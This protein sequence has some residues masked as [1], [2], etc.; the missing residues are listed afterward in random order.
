LGNIKYIIGDRILD[1][2]MPQPQTRSEI[3]IQKLEILANKYPKWYGIQ[4][5]ILACVGYAYIWVLILVVCL[6]FYYKQTWFDRYLLLTSI[7]KTIFFAILSF[8]LF[9][10][11]FTHISPPKGIDLNLQNRDNV[12]LKTYLKNISLAIGSIQIDRVIVTTDVNIDLLQL[13][14]VGLLGRKQTLLIIGMPLMLA[15]NPLQLKAILACEFGLLSD[16]IPR[17]NNWV[18][19]QVKTYIYLLDN[20][21][22]NHKF[23]LLILPFWRWYVPLLDTY[24]LL[25]RRQ[26]Q[27]NADRLAAKIVGTKNLVNAVV[28]LEV[29]RQFISEKFW[30]DIDRNHGIEPQPP[31]NIFELMERSILTECNPEDAARWLKASLDR[32]SDLQNIHP[33]LL[34]RLLALGY[35]D[36]SPDLAVGVGSTHNSARTYLGNAF[37]SIIAR[38]DRDWVVAETRSW[39][40]KFIQLQRAKTSVDRLVDKFDRDSLTIDES[41]RLATR[42]I[43]LGEI[44]NSIVMF[45]QILA[46]N[47]NHAKTN[48]WLGTILL[49][50]GNLAGIEYLTTAMNVDPGTIFGA[51]TT[52]RQ[53]A[54][55]IADLDPAAADNLK[56]IAS[57]YY[58]Y[59]LTNSRKDIKFKTKDLYNKHQ[60]D[61]SLLDMLGLK[62]LNL[63]EIDHLYAVAKSR[64]DNL[65]EHYIF[66]TYSFRDR[67]AI[68]DNED[69]ERM[70][71]ALEQ[72]LEP[73]GL[74]TILI[75]KQD[76]YYERDPVIDRL[77]SIPGT[78]IY[79]RKKLLANLADS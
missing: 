73:I 76:G 38:L 68:G 59:V 44:D 58:L 47:P 33:Y 20:V 62:L 35:S 72:T 61:R 55:K 48:L 67:S 11:L 8:A 19:R 77:R 66:A 15:L 74:M 51:A 56:K 43:E 17:L 37:D 63:V 16:R 10:G 79:N 69:I 57:E 6:Y 5:A 40:Q 42:K 2:S 7:G 34:V 23:D 53:F 14:R 25:L 31:A 22:I 3:S 18:D 29:Y 71:I 21:V 32:S 41:W 54:D 30:I 12:Q 9:N 46:T 39:Q 45:Y 65:L 75:F 49:E 13:P 50:T 36:M 27:A 78:C 52:I 24:S 26:A 4:V 70:Y 64:T 28:A 1:V 60:I